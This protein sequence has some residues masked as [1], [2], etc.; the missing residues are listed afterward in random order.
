MPYIL[1]LYTHLIIR[2]TEYKKIA[3]FDPKMQIDSAIQNNEL[4]VSKFCDDRQCHQQFI[5]KFFF[6]IAVFL[7]LRTKSVAFFK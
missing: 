3:F 6:K 4:M 1:I 7:K 2:V 5:K